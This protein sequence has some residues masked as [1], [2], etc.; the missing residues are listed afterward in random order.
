MSFSRPSILRAATI[1]GGFAATFVALLLLAA[2]GRA[3][4][5]RI[6]GEEQFKPRVVELTISTPAFAEPTKVHVD[7]PVGYDAD[8][9][10]RWPT[11]YFLAG[12]MNTYKTFNTFVDGV[13]LTKDYPSIIV[14]PNGDSGYWSDWYNGGA[15]GP[16]MYETYVI[17][18]LIPL[19]DEHFRTRA[20]RSQRAVM[21]VSMGAYG[22]MMFAARHPDL[23]SAA[24]S[25]S[26]AVDSNTGPIGAALSVSP[27]FQ[28]G[29]VDAIYGPRATQEIRWRGHNPTDLADNLRG[30]DL[31]LRTANGVLNPGIGENPLS[32]DAISCVVEKGVHDAS[33]SMNGKLDDLRIPHLWKNYGDGCHTKQNF[34]RQLIDTFQVFEESFAGPAAAPSPFDYRSIEPEFDVWGWHISTD[35]ERAPQFLEMKTASPEGLTLT[36]SGTTA[37]TSP[38]VF[39]DADRVELEN[40]LPKRAVPDASGRIRFTVDLG[41][42]DTEQQYTL[43]AIPSRVSRTVTFTPSPKPGT[44]P[45]K[46]ARRCVVPKVIGKTVKRARKR[47]LRAHCRLGKVSGK[48]RASARVVSQHP[49]PRKRVRPG[50]KVRVRVLSRP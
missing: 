25:I 16:P 41:S 14:S 31:Q 6:I 29:S 42:P 3:A 34:E 11:T 15:H 43:G 33:V 1:A 22:S 49:K 26:G 10:R 32:A 48:R 44:G 2:P 40:A 45:G 4:E 46:T 28:G 19:I 50:T 5:A 23:F 39:R 21:G 17:D 35:P 30:L 9:A 18:Q 7:L 27:T 12:T 20:E 37:V 36:G 47:L 38:P 24:A 13:G 8:P